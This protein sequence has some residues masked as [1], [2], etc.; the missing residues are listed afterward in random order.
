IPLHI[1]LMF[2]VIHNI[3]SLSR[4]IS[5]LRNRNE[6]YGWYMLGFWFF[7]IGIWI[8]QPRIIE[9]LKVPVTDKMS[10]E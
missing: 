9:L 4:C 8:I 7:P 5:K 2:F 6:V 1:I 3:Y 10:V